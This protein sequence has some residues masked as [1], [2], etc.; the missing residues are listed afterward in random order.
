MPRE[1]HDDYSDAQIEALLAQQ[2]HVLA[3][4]LGQPRSASATTRA[5]VLLRTPADDALSYPQPRIPL[6]V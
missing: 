5:R 2:R 3:C 1:R 4:S 6:P